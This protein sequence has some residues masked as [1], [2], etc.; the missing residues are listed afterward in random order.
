M[1]P[2]EQ[3]RE[4]GAARIAFFVVQYPLWCSPSLLNAAHALAERGYSVDIFTDSELPSHFVRGGDLPIQVHAAGGAAAR[5]PAALTPNS[6]RR[7]AAFRVRRALPGAAGDLALDLWKVLFRELPRT[8]RCAFR[9]R[10]VM[11]SRGAYQCFIGAEVYG[12]AAATLLGKLRGVPTAY[13]SLELYPWRESRRPWLRAKKWL[14]YLCHRAAPLTIIQDE[15]RADFLAADNGVAR[16]SMVVVPSAA[17]GGRSAGRG[18]HLRARLG[19]P[20]AKKILLHAGTLADWSCAAALAEAAQTWRD[21]WVLVLH[22]FGSREYVEEVRGKCRAPGR[23]YLSLEPVPYGELDE[24]IGSADIGLALYEDLGLNHTLLAGASGKLSHYLKCGLP[25]VA[26]GYQSLRGVV[27]ANRC[28]VCVASPAE[29]AAAAREIFDDYD[30]YRA[31]AFRCYEER[32]NF[33]DFF[34]E[35]ARRI[36]ILRP[37]PGGLLRPPRAADSDVLEKRRAP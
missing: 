15:A 6:L 5:R 16:S 4:G 20:A 22:G 23:V 34:G 10:S 21:D 32:L 19:I 33:D 25:V 37:P 7:R 14:E 18:D 35:A 17:R 1:R 11:R 8:A 2:R 26:S 3:G 29:V 31:N 12:L 9:A 36:D 13:W 24:L 27:E 30:A 28:G